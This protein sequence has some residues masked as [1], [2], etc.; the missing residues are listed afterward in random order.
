LRTAVI[1]PA[2]Q[3]EPSQISI[4]DVRKLNYL[5]A[6]HYSISDDLA[7]VAGNIRSLGK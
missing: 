1:H 3:Y 7:V 6:K 5:Y 2:N 4:S